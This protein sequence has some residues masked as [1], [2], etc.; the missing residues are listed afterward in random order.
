MANCV[1]WLI[2]YNYENF[3]TLQ[4]SLNVPHASMLRRYAHMHPVALLR[5]L[6]WLV[7]LMLVRLPA[8]K[9]PVVIR[10]SGGLTL[11]I[12]LSVFLFSFCLS[13]SFFL[14]LSVFLQLYVFF[15]T[16]LSPSSLTMHLSNTLY[17]CHTDFFFLNDVHSL[18][19]PCSTSL[20]FAPGHFIQISVMA[21]H[22]C[23]QPF[24]CSNM[25][26]GEISSLI[27][28]WGQHPFKLKLHYCCNDGVIGE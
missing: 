11:L 16:S 10:P 23:M 24:W 21:T 2:Y 1:F 5:T 6:K 20:P 7:S 22:W 17:V 4:V 28:G 19:S 8:V 15:P 18:S 27:Y 26:I 3:L 12:S 25:L 13:A 14:C 9:F